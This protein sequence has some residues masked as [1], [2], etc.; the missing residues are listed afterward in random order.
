M[1]SAALPQGD[2]LTH[3]RMSPSGGEQGRLEFAPMNDAVGNRL[4]GRLAIPNC[5]EYVRLDW[6]PLV[7]PAL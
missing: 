2:L 5:V 7:V 1:D 4:G 6:I 3:P